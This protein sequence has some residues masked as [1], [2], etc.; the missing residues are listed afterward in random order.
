MSHAATFDLSDELATLFQRECTG[1]GKLACVQVAIEDE[2]F[3]VANT[4]PLG[5]SAEED[6]EAAKRLLSED[7]AA[8]LLFRLLRGEEKQPWALMSFVP[9]TAPVKQKMLY[10][11]AK[12]TLRKKLPGDSFGQESHWSAMDEVMMGGAAALSGVDVQ[13]VMTEAERMV[14]HEDMS[15]AAEAAAGKVKSAG[16]AFPLVAA[17]SAKVDEF[18]KGSA[19]LVVL[20][21]IDEQIQLKGAGSAAA[22]SDVRSAVPSAEPSYALFRWGAEG[23][24]IFIFTCPDDAPVRAKM[25]HAS[26]KSSMLEGLQAFG[27]TVD[28]SLEINDP[29]DVTEEWLEAEVRGQAQGASGA[30]ATV[31]AKA[32]PRGGRKLVKKP[33]AS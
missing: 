19:A 15:S 29:A 14:L 25:L 23:K 7:A 30:S 26:S 6:F 18:S 17:A 24:V 27:V 31:T 12:D 2:K 5:T 13:H 21:I 9:D 22:A 11:N 3:T 16:L 1:E 33:A 32:A 8:Y 4:I 20:E 28:K 10:A